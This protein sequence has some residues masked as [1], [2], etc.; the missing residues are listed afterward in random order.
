MLNIYISM[1]ELNFCWGMRT[2]EVDEKIAE[3]GWH[4]TKLLDDD[5][6]SSIRFEKIFYDFNYEV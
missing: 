1:L 3:V 2:G 4:L 6:E 5:I